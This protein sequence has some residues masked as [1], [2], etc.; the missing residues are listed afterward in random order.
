MLQDLKY[1]KI[2]F[3]DQNTRTQQYKKLPMVYVWWKYE[4]CLSVDWQMYFLTCFF[5]LFLLLLQR[6][7]WK[8]ADAEGP[9]SHRHAAQWGSVWRQADTAEWCVQGSA[10]VFMFAPWFFSQLQCYF[11]I[12]VFFFPFFF[13]F[14]NFC[15]K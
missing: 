6:G 3:A 5:S 9:D 1:W 14:F 4:G 2:I 11:S 10:S 15:N 8:C 13:F 12:S 7:K